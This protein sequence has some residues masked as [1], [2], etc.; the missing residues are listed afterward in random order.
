[1][2]STVRTPPARTHLSE[3]A[4]FSG[5][6]VSTIT[7]MSDSYS[8]L[9][10]PA[11]RHCPFGHPHLQ[12]PPDPAPLTAAHPPSRPTLTPRCLP[13]PPLHA[14]Q[15]PPAAPPL[16][17]CHMPQTTS[18]SPDRRLRTT[19]LAASPL[20]T[21]RMT[22]G[23]AVPELWHQRSHASAS[24]ASAC[25]GWTSMRWWRTSM[26]THGAPPRAGA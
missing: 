12:V 26:K 13:R 14:G 21:C 1:M 5:F 18:V 24:L 23:S 16:A 17:T 22:K 10:S 3:H 15:L 2:T 6:P 25:R 9:Q 7:K 19:M 4:T 8:D 20:A 11:A